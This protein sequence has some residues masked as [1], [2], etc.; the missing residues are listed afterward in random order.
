MNIREIWSKL[1]E[2]RVDRKWDKYHTEEALAR[3]LMIEGAEL[4]RLYQWGQN[5]TIDELSDEVADCMI[6][7]MYLCIERGLN[8]EQIIFDK[9][10][11]NAEKYPI[12][13]K[14]EW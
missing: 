13:G 11:K 12:G 1:I 2:F 3:S 14:N 10:K 9:I 5:P 8:P 4:N 7:C 6:Y